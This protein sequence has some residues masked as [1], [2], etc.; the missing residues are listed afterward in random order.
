MNPWPFVIGAYV[1]T[2]GGT[3]LVTA[4]AWASMRRAEKDH[5][6]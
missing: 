6:R 1:I 3:A 2:L 4:W 5:D